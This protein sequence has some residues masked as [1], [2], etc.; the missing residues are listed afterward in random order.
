MEKEK[1]D[2]QYF[3]I[4]SYCSRYITFSV[5]ST[6]CQIFDFLLFEVVSM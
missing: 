3:K 6:F 4:H 1:S 5:L 2:A